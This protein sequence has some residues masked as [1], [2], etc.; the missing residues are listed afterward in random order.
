MSWT[1]E[2]RSSCHGRAAN[3]RL[4]P[5]GSHNST[6]IPP[7]LESIDATWPRCPFNSADAGKLQSTT[8]CCTSK[9]VTTF[10]E[11]TETTGGVD[12]CS[13]C[14]SPLTN[15]L[16][17]SPST[18]TT[19]AKTSSF[20][21]HMSFTTCTMCSKGFTTSTRSP[22]RIS[23]TITLFEAS[24]A[25]DED[26]SFSLQSL[27]SAPVVALGLLLN[28]RRLISMLRFGEEPPCSAEVNS[29][30]SSSPIGSGKHCRPVIDGKVGVATSCSALAQRCESSTPGTSTT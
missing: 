5:T 25:P 6:I 4:P 16:A 17:W 8:L 11:E 14:A 21:E 13:C 28:F 26:L 22:G 29:V 1:E 10:S 18:L 30:Q 27:P 20:I 7:R 9:R 12:R 23:S 3:L 2:A 19:V 15:N 24:G